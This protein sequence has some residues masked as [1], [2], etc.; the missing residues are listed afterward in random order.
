M[1]PKVLKTLKENLN[2]SNWRKARRFLVNYIK[3]CQ[4]A[5]KT[6]CPEFFRTL[7][8]HKFKTYLT[9]ISFKPQDNFPLD[10]VLTFILNIMSILR[11]KTGLKELLTFITGADDAKNKGQKSRRN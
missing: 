1:I 6:S 9:S 2:D 7:S 8:H 5:D 11:H 4:E 3:M 10:R